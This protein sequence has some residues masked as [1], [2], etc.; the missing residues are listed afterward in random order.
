MVRYALLFTLFL[1]LFIVT[2]S[3]QADKLSPNI[4]PSKKQLIGLPI[5]IRIFKE[6]AIAELFILKNDQYQLIKTFPICHF[7]GGLGPKKLEN[8]LKSPEGFYQIKVGALNPNSRFH[9]SFNI[10]YPNE[11][12]KAHGFTGR[13]LMVHGGCISEGCYAIGNQNIEELYYFINQAMA[14]GQQRIDIHIF[15]F[16]M[17]EKNLLRYQHSD[18][19]QFWQQLKPAYDYFEQNKMPPFIYIS[20]GQYFI[21]HHL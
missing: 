18:N 8:D 4:E 12:D 9:L 5:Y 21:Y 3:V 20:N 17:T 2:H 7:S 16:K 1:S 11:F 19:Y 10:G 13:Y 6:E 14:G 15:P